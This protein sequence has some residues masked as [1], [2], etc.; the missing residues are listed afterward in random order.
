MFDEKSFIFLTEN[1]LLCLLEDMITE[2]KKL[3]RENTEKEHIIE[4]FKNLKVV[5][6]N[7]ADK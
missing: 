7:S 1:E 3:Q 4:N 5:K 2:M 6:H